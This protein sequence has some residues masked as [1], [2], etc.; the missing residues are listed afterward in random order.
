[1][2]KTIIVTGAAGAL[3]YVVANMLAEA[4]HNVH[5]LDLAASAPAG[6]K[7][8]FHGGAN[9]TQS[10]AV[11]SALSPIFAAEK[12]IDALVN[13]VGGFVWETVDGGSVESWDKMYQMNV[14]PTLLMAQA[15][16]PH[17]RK[18]NGAIVN[19]GANAARISGEGMGAYAASK[20]GVHKLTESLAAEEKNSRVRVNA[21]LPTIIDT[22]VN[23]K[24]MPDA[25]FASW[26]RPESIGQLV[27]FLTSDAADA[28]TGA[29]IPIANRT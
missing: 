13:I 20:A 6:A 17:L 26:V 12:Q 18:T 7:F 23:R 24:D 5:G 3:G 19:I 15:L 2:S 10:D 25:D 9:L 8:A 27:A 22:P 21:I 1:M 16:L 29:C 11:S 4:G 14:R 28:I